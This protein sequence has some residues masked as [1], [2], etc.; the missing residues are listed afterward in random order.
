[1]AQV[2]TDRVI[3]LQF[4]D[5]LYRLFL[6]F[7]AGGNIVLTDADLTILA[8]LRNV[9]EGAEHEQYR[10]GLKYDVSQRQNASGVPDLTKERVKVGRGHDWLGGVI[11]PHKGIVGSITPAFD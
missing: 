2:G 8:L 3:E 9:N 4:S 6:E 5:G 1:M 7:Y 10:A 11:L